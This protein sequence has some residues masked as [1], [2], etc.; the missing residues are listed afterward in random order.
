MNLQFTY[1][2][3][4]ENGDVKSRTKTIS[5]INEDV[6]Q[7]SYQQFSQAYHKLIDVQEFKAYLV[8]KEEL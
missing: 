6:G 7:E 4:D 2:I 3:T 1:K 8:N 5:N